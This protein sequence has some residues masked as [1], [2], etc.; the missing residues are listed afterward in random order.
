MGAANKAYERDGLESRRNSPWHADAVAI[1]NM[2]I[3]S[4]VI[5]SLRGTEANLK[6]RDTYGRSRIFCLSVFFYF[7][8]WRFD[9]IPGHGL[10]IRGFAITLTGHIT[11]GRT[12]LDK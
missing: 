10:P 1:N 4:N 11:L 8:L 2:T 7:P 6:S 3:K 12:P 9:P 5:F